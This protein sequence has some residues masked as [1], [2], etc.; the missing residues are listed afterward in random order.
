MG[1]GP[2]RARN[3]IQMRRREPEYYNQDFLRRYRRFKK[4]YIVVENSSEKYKYE[5]FFRP[6][7]HLTS[8]HIGQYNK[9][10]YFIN[11][12]LDFKIVKQGISAF[13]LVVES[14][15]FRW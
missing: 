6:K 9:Y 10:R 14:W 7:F 2:A 5:F 3:P 1:R 8:Y 4:S 12:V 11:F 15:V 13:N